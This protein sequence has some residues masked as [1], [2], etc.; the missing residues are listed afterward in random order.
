MKEISDDY[1]LLNRT[2]TDDIGCLY[3][4]PKFT[5]DKNDTIAYTFNVTLENNR[6]NLSVI[7]RELFNPKE[8][9]CTVCANSIIQRSQTPVDAQKAQE[10]F[11]AG[12]LEQSDNGY[13]VSA[14]LLKL[15]GAK[16]SDI[17]ITGIATA[18]QM[19]YNYAIQIGKQLLLSWRSSRD[20]YRNQ[21]C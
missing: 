1:H 14:S 4:Y 12:L 9:Y 8:C 5:L 6:L 18:G 19:A 10:L 13:K 20:L 3:Q 11:N 2:G 15:I 17:V 7:V 16:K 21:A